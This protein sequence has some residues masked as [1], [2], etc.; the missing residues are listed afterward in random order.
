MITHHL[1]PPSL[2]AVKSSLGHNSLLVK[3]QI[4]SGATITA[5]ASITIGAAYLAYHDRGVWWISTLSSTIINFSSIGEL[6]RK[7]K[8]NKTK[9]IL[10]LNAALLNC[11]F[12]GGLSVT[13]LSLTQGIIVSFRRNHLSFLLFQFNLLTCLMGYALPLSLSV[14]RSVYYAIH[15]I[16]MK[17]R[18]SLLFDHFD[19]RRGAGSN[20][21]FYLSL[22]QSDLVLKVCE[23]LDLSL[24]DYAWPIVAAASQQMTLQQFDRMV[25]QA[26]ALPFDFFTELEDVC[27]TQ[28]NGGNHRDNHFYAGIKIGLQLIAKKDLSLA[29]KRLITKVPPL[30]PRIL[31]IH[32]FFDLFKGDILDQANQFVQETLSEMDQWQEVVQ[33]YQQF[34]HDVKRLKLDTDGLDRKGLEKGGNDF[35]IRYDNLNV[36]SAQLRCEL[37]KVYEA[38]RMWQHCSPLFKQVRDLPFV[39][40][41]DLLQILRDGALLKEIDDIYRDFNGKKSVCDQLELVNNRLICLDDKLEEERASSIIFLAANCGFI[42]EDF[43][44]LQSW[45]SLDSPHDL[46]HM[47]QKIGLAT[48]V[49]LCKHAIV[50]RKLPPLSKEVIQ[51]RLKHYIHTLPKPLLIFDNDKKKTIDKSSDLRKTVK[52]ISRFIYYAVKSMLLLV[53]VL[54]HPYEGGA[55]LVFGCCFFSMQRFAVPGINMISEATSSFVEDFLI[56][57]LA[58]AL[59][60]RRIYPLSHLDRE[61]AHRFAEGSLFSKI[62]IINLHTTLASLVSSFTVRL[63]RSAYHYGS[64]FQAIAISRDIVGVLD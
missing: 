35:K 50:S 19:G 18:L 38:K 6:L 46:E 12:L 21:L 1:H 42:Q 41:K 61:N 28:G 20:Y 53:P 63:G 16:E 48:E 49:E 22:F 64:F 43:E 60:N 44:N 57:S 33:R 4:A 47:M 27:S 56:G 58:S 8:N 52:K 24:S 11:L 15:D 23:V 34:S 40:G 26:E 36:I 37:H 14:L 54:I 3:N 5:F 9:A 25:N 29:V 62:I 10:F 13:S 31:S 17:K 59:F 51:K 32:Q 2:G 55:G 39:C 30:I 7:G 45:L